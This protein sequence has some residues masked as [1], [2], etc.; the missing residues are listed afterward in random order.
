M[1]LAP[2]KRGTGTVVN[3]PAQLY[4]KLAVG[5]CQSKVYIVY[6]LGRL[7]TICC[8]PVVIHVIH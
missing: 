5:D 2:N 1:M 3:Q 7:S 6:H 4:E 8:D